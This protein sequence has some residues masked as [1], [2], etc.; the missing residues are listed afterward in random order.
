M[1][2]FLFFSGMEQRS[3]GHESFVHKEARK[4]H[5]W[6]KGHTGKTMLF[7]L[8]L[9]AGEDVVVVAECN[10]LYLGFDIYVQV[11]SQGTVL[12][13]PKCNTIMGAS[14]YFQKHD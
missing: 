8:S 14:S 3:Q 1:F 6:E 4:C 5:D 13:I 12:D 7:Q 10:A 2:R 9:W 11:A